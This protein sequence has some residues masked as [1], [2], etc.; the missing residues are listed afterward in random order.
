MKIRIH[1]LTPEDFFHEQVSIDINLPA[2]PAPGDFIWL[3]SRQEK[4]LNDKAEKFRDMYLDY[5][6]PNGKD[7]PV[8][9]ADCIVVKQR[10]F[11]LDEKTI[12]ITIGKE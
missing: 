4:K 1:I 6:Y 8:D 12:H 11:N 7:N 10:W 9:I 3:S 2:V 5:V